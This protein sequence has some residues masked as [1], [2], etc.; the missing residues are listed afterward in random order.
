[1]FKLD[2]A[3]ANHAFV[4]FA[5]FHVFAPG[6]DVQPEFH[7]GYRSC[8]AIGEGRRNKQ[9]FQIATSLDTL[10]ISNRFLLGSY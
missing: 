8:Q 1:M 6:H 3:C 7:P 5:L 9:T 4:K 10:Y 2:Q